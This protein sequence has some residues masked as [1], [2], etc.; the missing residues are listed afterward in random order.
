MLPILLWHET[1]HVFGGW[2]GQNGGCIRYVVAL[3]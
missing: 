1:R 3:D 2:F